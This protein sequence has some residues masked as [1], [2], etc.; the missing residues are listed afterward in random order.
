MLK[1]SWVILLSDI[2]LIVDQLLDKNIFQTSVED[3]QTSYS[4]ERIILMALITS[5]IQGSSMTS[6]SNFLSIETRAT[7]FDVWML[8]RMK[9][10]F[11]QEMI[12]PPYLINGYKFDLSVHVVFTSFQVKLI[13]CIAS[14]L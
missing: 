2:L 4:L 6:Q 8:F 11:V 1:D 12:H 10:V 3:I 13:D 9:N 5:F 7:I 14:T